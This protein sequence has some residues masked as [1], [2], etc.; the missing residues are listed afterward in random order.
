MSDKMHGNK[1][2]NSNV[3]DSSKAGSSSG[4]NDRDMRHENEARNKNSNRSPGQLQSHQGQQ[5]KQGQPGQHSNMKKPEA[6]DDNKH[7][8]DANG[9]SRTPSS[10][11]SASR[12]KGHSQQR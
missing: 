2:H 4:N 7:D 5:N 6:E 8:D 3:D 1:P 11:S 9:T 12:D 10:P